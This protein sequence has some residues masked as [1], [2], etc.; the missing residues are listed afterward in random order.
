MVGPRIS[1]NPLQIPYMVAEKLISN[2]DG[3]VELERQKFEFRLCVVWGVL[4]LWV[5]T[6]QGCT[7]GVRVNCKDTGSQRSCSIASN[8]L[9]P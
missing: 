4:L 1:W 3:L 5:G 2:L 6:L 7:P 9:K 8:P